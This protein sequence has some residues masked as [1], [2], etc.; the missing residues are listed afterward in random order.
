MPDLFIILGPDHTGS[1]SAISAE[2]WTTPFS[3][4]KADIEFAKVLEATAEQN[5]GIKINNKAHE[6]EHSIEVQ[7]PFL[8]FVNKDHMK[9]MKMLAIMVSHDVNIKKLAEDIKAAIKLTKKTVCFITSSDFTHY[10]ENFG[11]TPF[12]YN[13][14]ESLLE[15]DNGAIETI[16]KLDSS[17]FLNYV[18]K[19]G[20]TIC[21]TLPIA[22][23]IDIIWQDVSDVHLLSY[24]TSVDITEGKDYSHSVGYAAM[25]FK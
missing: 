19:T 15:M 23:M 5:S 8:Q 1:G 14:K 13:I 20:A 11:F 22:L 21:G 6:K 3:D 10:G 17:V 2:D 9:T 12:I 16:K 24:Y 7:L 4:L 18:K 25:V